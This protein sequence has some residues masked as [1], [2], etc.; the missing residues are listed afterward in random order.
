[1]TPSPTIEEWAMRKLSGVLA[2]I[3]VALGCGYLV[4][5]DQFMAHWNMLAISAGR[6]LAL[7]RATL[8]QLISGKLTID[9]PSG[10]SG[11][12]P[13]PAIARPEQNSSPPPKRARPP[14]IVQPARMPVPAA[15]TPD[16]DQPPSQIS[17]PVTDA[18]AQA[19]PEAAL[20]AILKHEVRE[21]QAKEETFWTEERIQE[22]LKNGAPKARSAPCIALCDNND[23]V[24]EINMPKQPADGQKK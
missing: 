18:P 3:L 4:W 2:A 5:P 16:Q 24:I 6:Q 21:N 22:A 12:N 14:E 19:T 1:M 10:S 23:T 11:A 9:A 7:E 20:G 8:D 17:A 15:T 13:P